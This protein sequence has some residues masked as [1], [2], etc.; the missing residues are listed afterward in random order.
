M[1]WQ[2]RS[3]REKTQAHEFFFCL[4]HT[5]NFQKS[6][7]TKDANVN[8][9]WELGVMGVG[10][11]NQFRKDGEMSPCKGMIEQEKNLTDIWR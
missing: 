9:I 5:N 8:W 7:T 2:Y 1:C 3:Y 6:N 11:K 10:K 4:G